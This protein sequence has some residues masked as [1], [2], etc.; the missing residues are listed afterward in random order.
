MIRE[1]NKEDFDSI[2]NLWQEMMDFHIERSDLYHITHDAKEIYSDYLTY[3]L[4]SPEYVTLVFEANNKIKGYL[5]ATESSD[6]PI[7]RDKV[8]LI[9]ELTISE[10]YRN[11]GIGETLVDEIEKYFINKGIKRME[12]MVSDFNEISKRFW[13]KN[14]YSPY[15]LMCVKMLR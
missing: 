10:K 2:T 1:A 9:L 11:K 5:M 8:G 4:K 6:P 13:F 3:V 14:G 15:N 12:C 7:Y